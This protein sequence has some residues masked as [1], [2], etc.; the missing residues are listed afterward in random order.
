MDGAQVTSMTSPL[1][2]SEQSNAYDKK[3]KSYDL[4]KMA[5]DAFCIQK[6]KEVQKSEELASK[7]VE[8]Q[9]EVKKRNIITWEM[10][11]SSNALKS[12]HSKNDENGHLSKIG[13]N[14][15]I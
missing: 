7:K 5:Y 9:E 13:P 3:V 1:Y 10:A 12:Y 15:G 14:K 4:A 11:D 2:W 6:L 8:E